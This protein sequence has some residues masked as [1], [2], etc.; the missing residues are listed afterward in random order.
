M[1]KYILTTGPA[2]ANEVPLSEVHSEKTFTASTVPM[3]ALRRSRRTSGTSAARF[4][5]RSS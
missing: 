2:L 3:A 1:Q 5:A 4:P